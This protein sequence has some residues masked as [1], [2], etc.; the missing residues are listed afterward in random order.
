MV[1]FFLPWQEFSEPF[2]FT[3]SSRLKSCEEYQWG[4]CDIDDSFFGRQSIGWGAGVGSGNT[5][6]PPFRDSHSAVCRS[7]CSTQ[8]FSIFSLRI[9]FFHYPKTIYVAESSSFFNVWSWIESK[10][11]WWPAAGIA[12]CWETADW[13]A[14]SRQ[15]WLQQRE[16]EFRM[17][18]GY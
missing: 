10:S 12:L 8:Y 3:F 18:R 15:S 1:F 7:T 6:G 16:R 2:Y 11:L 17:V 14:G 4:H 13:C 9:N 5:Q